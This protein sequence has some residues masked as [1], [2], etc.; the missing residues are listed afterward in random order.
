MKSEFFLDYKRWKQHKTPNV[1]AIIGIWCP[2]IQINKILN[3]TKPRMVFY[4]CQ[5]KTVMLYN[6][7]PHSTAQLN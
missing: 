7:R 3:G 5:K 6:N 2:V 4:A 1:L